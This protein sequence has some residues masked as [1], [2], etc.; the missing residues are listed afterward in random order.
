MEIEA[1]KEIDTKSDPLCYCLENFGNMRWID[2][3]D[4][5]PKQ[6]MVSKWLYGHNSKAV[7]I[8]RKL[9][10]KKYM[11]CVSYDEDTQL[12]GTGKA[13]KLFDKEKAA[14]IG[15]KK[16][17]AEEF[18]LYI[19]RQKHDEKIIKPYDVENTTYTTTSYYVLE[20]S[21]LVAYDPIKVRKTDTGN[22]KD[23]VYGPV[24]RGKDNGDKNNRVC[25]MVIG[26][27]DELKKLFK[28]VVY[29]KHAADTVDIV[30]V[31]LMNIGF[32]LT[33]HDVMKDWH[34]TEQ[35]RNGFPKGRL[36]DVTLSKTSKINHTNV[37]KM[38]V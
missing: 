20:A 23:Y 25:F 27:L 11:A 33:L 14:T 4:P 9:D 18:G 31:A 3:K 29:R 16:E 24:R 1:K 28:S 34:T 6:L 36:C 32:L 22:N 8:M 13:P 19:L 38:I 30:G 12:A 7:E 10:K 21:Q 17:L 5:T 37:S 26:S 2:G 35:T 15:L